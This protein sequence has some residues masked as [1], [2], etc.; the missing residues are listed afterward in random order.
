MNRPIQIGKLIFL[1]VILA[2]GPSAAETGRVSPRLHRLAI[3]AANRR[4]WSALRRYARAAPG[5]EARGLA[6]FALGYREYEARLYEPAAVDLL[7]A[8]ETRCL[9]ADYAE[10]YEAL[11][12]QTLNRNSNAAAVL[13]DFSSRYPHSPLELQAVNLLARLLIQQGHPQRA[14]QTLRAEPKALHHPSS[15]LL[16]AKAYDEAQ[17]LAEAAKLAE[18]IYYEYPTAPEAHE[19]GAE[20]AKLQLRLGPQYPA[21]SDGVKNERAKVLFVHGDARDALIEYSNLLL[22]EPESPFRSEWQLDRT[23]CLL[24]LG[25]YSDAV[26]ALQS[27]LREN[28]MMDAERLALLVDANG[29]AGDEPSMLKA[30]EELY[31]SSPHSPFYGRALAYAGGYFARQ[32]FWQTAAQYY[33]PLAHGF[34]GASYAEEASW[35]AAWYGVLAGKT[36]EARAAMIAYLKNYPSSERAPAAL[37]W[38]GWI[39]ERE[40]SFAEV[41]ALEGNLRFANSYYGFK[42]RGLLA[43]L[44]RASADSE[45]SAP[46]PAAAPLA[47]PVTLPSIPVPPLK[48]LKQDG[49]TT[50][51]LLLAPAATLSALGLKTLAN[52]CADAIAAN[53]RDNPEVFLA[54][55][56]LLAADGNVSAALFAAK[57]AVPHYENYPFDALPER[58]WNLL[59]PRRYWPLVRRYARANHLDPYLVMG[60]IRQES[61]F[62]PRATSSAEARGLMQMMPQTIERGVR[63]RWRRRRVVRLLY[64]PRYNIR[65]SCRYLRDLFRMFG[66][67]EAEALAAYNAG[68]T[69]VKQWLA[70]G[71]LR[72]PAMFPESIPFMDTR[73][74]VE[75]ILRDAAIYRALLTGTA[76]FRYN[77]SFTEKEP[78]HAIRQH[79]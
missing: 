28:P 17:D 4:G 29:R 47:L 68:D 67:N 13:E 14:I 77:R 8:A 7:R 9:L 73:A 3:R 15:L 24:R 44:A 38:L 59:Y 35:R 52:G 6:Y 34:P 58:V 53:H 33:Q 37:Y 60:V 23:R 49:L 1:L 78:H 12:D 66:G 19:A 74:Y 11:T 64:S 31:K 51:D 20:L 65:V 62:N 39:D 71:N 18:Q 45:H 26:N 42:A 57:N 69:R 25:R 75:S 40:G 30:L 5:R 32:G 70:N 48:L 41:S 16:L 79:S 72:D 46:P 10:Y 63:G 43:E 56:S 61:A 27:S 55:A 36:S 50:A 54:Q 21:V 2:A 22:N 76:G